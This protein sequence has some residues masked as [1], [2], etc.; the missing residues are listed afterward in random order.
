MVTQLLYSGLIAALVVERLL[1]LRRSR[2]NAVW[3]LSR[4]GVEYGRGHLG[5]MKLLHTG[6]FVFSLVEVWLGGARFVPALGWPMLAVLVL[7]QVLRRWAMAALGPRWN[8][9]VIVVPGLPAVSSGPF[10]FVRHPN[11]LAVVLE[12]LAIPLVH[13]AWVTAVA[14]SLLNAW[15]LRVRI[16]CE[17]R[18]L[19]AHSSYAQRLGGRARFW[20]AWPSRS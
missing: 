12:G 14:F 20:P 5:Y 9:R 1:E 2:R 7:G 8:V 16:R 13:S 4:G 17:E 6:L 15:L 18:A 11:Y 10:R 19:S 3:A